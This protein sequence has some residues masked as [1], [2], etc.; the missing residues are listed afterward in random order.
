MGSNPI[1]TYPSRR[2]YNGIINSSFGRGLYTSVGLDGKREDEA[3]VASGS[4]CSDVYATIRVV[5]TEPG[6]PDIH[7]Y[8]VK[9]F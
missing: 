5:D 1:L 8:Q 9:D 6:G 4:S 3:N 2:K 7:L